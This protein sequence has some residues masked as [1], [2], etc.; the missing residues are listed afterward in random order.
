[1]SSH[2]RG[3]SQSSLPYHTRRGAHGHE[4]TM[5]QQIPMPAPDDNTPAAW[6]RIEAEYRRDQKIS[7]A[8]EDQHMHDKYDATTD[9]LRAKHTELLEEHE[10]ILE[11]LHANKARCEKV[12]EEITRLDLQFFEA[13]E[14]VAKRRQDQDEK[15]RNFFD[16]NRSA[17]RGFNTTTAGTLPA[18]SN[19]ATPASDDTAIDE[20]SSPGLASAESSPLSQPPDDIADVTGAEIWDKQAKALIAPVKRL[21]LDN[22]YVRNILQ[23]PIKRRVAVRPGRKFSDETMHSIYEP[24]DCKGA[25]WLSCMIQATGEEQPIPCT[26]CKARTGVWDACVIVGG[27]DFPRC[28]NC[29]WNRQGCSGSSYHQDRMQD[30]DMRSNHYEDGAESPLPLVAADSAQPSR[31]GSSSG[32]FTPVNGTQLR[33]SV[34]NSAPSAPPKRTTLPNKKGGRKSL[35]TMA[36][37]NKESVVLKEEPKLAGDDEEAGAEVDPGPEILKEGLHLRHNGVEYTEPEIMRGVPLAR[38]SPQHPYWDHR[39]EDVKA[40]VQSKLTEWKAKY[41]LCVQTNKNRFLA[42][43]QVNRGKAIMAFLDNADFHPYQLVGKKFMSKGLVSYDTIFRLAQVIDELPKLFAKLKVDMTANDW[44]RERMHEL[45]TEHGEFFSLSKTVHELYHDPKLM[46]LRKRAGVGNIGRPSGVKKGMTSKHGAIRPKGA[47]DTPTPRKRRRPSTSGSTKSNKS[48]KSIQQEPVTRNGSEAMDPSTPTFIKKQRIDTDSC[49][50]PSEQNSE[51]VSPTLVQ[52]DADDEFRYDGYT[53]TD[54]YSG[55]KIV[56][57]DWRIYQI[58]TEQATTNTDQTQYWHWVPDQRLFEHQV[59]RAVNPTKWGVYNNP[60]NLHLRLAE[61]E[62]VEYTLDPGC[63][64][65]IVHTRRLPAGPAGPSS[66]MLVHF[67]RDRTLKRFLSFLKHDL[68]V[69]VV[70]EEK[71]R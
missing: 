70:L 69:K 20:H 35:P 5:A 19:V 1:M 61:L 66:K 59:L 2:H 65:I 62:K 68:P 7:R 38:I 31:E 50:G 30:P 27:S 16:Y 63:D 22:K 71:T 28:A 49:N 15:A 23:I 3:D 52:T 41:D 14:I 60:Y 37:T 12:E 53:S 18:A 57:A 32:G 40:T 46:A 21:K 36:S 42:G 67:K 13:K 29:E 43:R 34:P 10:R 51:T 64:K 39:W 47:N 26:A 54:S 45:Y 58:K 48:A 33:T 56:T 9:P 8:L 44:V 11:K 6:D 24:S 17:A 55:G 25:K 4:R